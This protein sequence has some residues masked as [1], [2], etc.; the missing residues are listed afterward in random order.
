MHF[1]T[2]R[3]ALLPG[4]VLRALVAV[5]R[6]ESTAFLPSEVSSFAAL[7]AILQSASSRMS[8]SFC[9]FVYCIQTP[10]S[11]LD[12]V[13]APLL[14]PVAEDL[15]EIVDLAGQSAFGIILVC[16]IIPMS[17]PFISDAESM[18]NI[19]FSETTMSQIQCF[20]YFL[21]TCVCM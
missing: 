21:L 15:P 17:E 5:Q 9:Y 19:I 12:G 3:S 2:F 6:V 8:N 20:V 11:V 18:S 14:S 13:L 16:R 7:I 10:R 4:N 1:V